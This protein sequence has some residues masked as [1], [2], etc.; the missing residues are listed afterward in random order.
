MILARF[1]VAAV[2]VITTMITTNMDRLNGYVLPGQRKNAILLLE[3]H[4]RPPWEHPS[5]T[6]LRLHGR[7]RY[8]KPRAALPES[9]R[10]KA[11]LREEARP[12]N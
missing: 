2:V 10:W 12:R 3:S 9:F 8:W 7:A 6:R 5:P 4:S 11:H 1:V